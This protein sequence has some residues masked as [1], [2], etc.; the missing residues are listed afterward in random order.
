V[1]LDKKNNMATK[2]LLSL[3]NFVNSKTSHSITAIVLVLVTMATAILIT[4]GSLSKMDDLKQTISNLQAIITLLLAGGLMG[5]CALFVGLT[6][7]LA[8]ENGVEHHKL[9]LVQFLLLGGGFAG[10][11]VLIFVGFT[12]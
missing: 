12:T 4:F 5:S 7:K 1:I 11:W 3:I 8:R 6:E 9:E 2:A 10:M